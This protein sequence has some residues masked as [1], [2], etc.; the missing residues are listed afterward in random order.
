MPLLVK[1][2]RIKKAG[3]AVRVLNRKKM[4]QPIN[5]MRWPAGAERMVR[6]KPMREDSRAYWVALKLRLVCP[7]IKA[8]KAAVP[9]PAAKFSCPII[10]ARKVVFTGR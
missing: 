1:L 6:G 3:M 4:G 2:L 5:S 8:M 10:M 9:A 7:A